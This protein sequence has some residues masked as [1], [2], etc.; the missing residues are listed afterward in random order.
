MLPQGAAEIGTGLVQPGL[1][2]S[3]LYSQMG[4][5]LSLRQPRQV[6]QD[7]RGPLT[8]WQ[9]RDRSMHPGSKFGRFGQISRSRCCVHRF[10]EALAT[11]HRFPGPGLA[12]WPCCQRRQ[13]FNPIPTNHRRTAPVGGGDRG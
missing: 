5:R 3:H 11:E 10:G 4:S 8:Q 7:D 13:T 6:V 9:T 2:C 12:P 1:D